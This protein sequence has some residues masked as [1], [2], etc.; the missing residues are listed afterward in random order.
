VVELASAVIAQ[1]HSIEADVSGVNDVVRIDA[2][3]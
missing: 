2:A 1:L 3:L